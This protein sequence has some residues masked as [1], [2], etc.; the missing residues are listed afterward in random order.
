M[1]TNKFDTHANLMKSNRVFVITHPKKSGHAE[2]IV[3]YP[4]DGAGRLRVSLRDCF[5]DTCE[6]SSGYAG[7]YGYDKLTAAISGLVIDG[8]K[9]TDHCG[10]DATSK[11][12]L[13]AYAKAETQEGKQKIVERARKAGYSF[14]N[15]SGTGGYCPTGKEGYQSCYKLSG[16]DYLRALGYRVITVG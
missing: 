6:F 2:I 3:K 12:L 10:E 15:W 7:G 4:N 11:K 9:L 13:N 8:H 16:L 5:G 14:N 1:S